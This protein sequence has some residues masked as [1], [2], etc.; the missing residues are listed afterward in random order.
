MLRSMSWL[1]TTS[2]LIACH[3]GVAQEFS[4]L[5]LSSLNNEPRADHCDE[6]SYSDFLQIGYGPR[7]STYRARF[8]A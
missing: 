1:I 3:V 5:R 2:I 6:W 7:H 8:S 4:L